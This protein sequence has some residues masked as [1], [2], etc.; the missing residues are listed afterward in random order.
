MR[1]LLMLMLTLILGC[2]EDSVTIP[3]NKADIDANTALIE[4]NRAMIEANSELIALLQVQ[5]DE[6]GEA[7]EDNEDAIRR[8]KRRYNQLARKIKEISRNQ[9]DVVSCNDELL[10][11]TPEGLIGPVLSGHYETV[12]TEVGE[13]VDEYE[14][15]TRRNWLGWCTR[16]ETIEAHISEGESEEIFVADSVSLEEVECDDQG[17]ED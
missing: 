1:V 16:Y 10:L 15:C 6:N 14:R 3:D 4:A 5:V 11:D 8:C 9:I 12:V 17:S 7:I 13:F 2:S